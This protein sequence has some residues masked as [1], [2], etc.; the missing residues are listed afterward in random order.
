MTSGGIV[1][2][3]ISVSVTLGFSLVKKAY[4]LTNVIISY[5]SVNK[6]VSVINL[7]QNIIDVCR[8]T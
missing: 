2:D 5:K 7:K 4:R 3:L 8:V 1:D 6:V